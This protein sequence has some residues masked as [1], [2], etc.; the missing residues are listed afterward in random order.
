MIIFKYRKF[1]GRE[2][3]N[4]TLLS[5]EEQ[6]FIMAH[7]L[8]YNKLIEMECTLGNEEMT[9]NQALSLRNEY[10][11]MK[12]EYDLNDEKYWELYDR[13]KSCGRL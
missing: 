13:A 11:A 1:G 6:N 9:K 12:K 3:M 7:E 5:K 4:W 8:M 10:N 2:K